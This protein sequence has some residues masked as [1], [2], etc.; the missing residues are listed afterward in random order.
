MRCGQRGVHP[1]GATSNAAN[2]NAGATVQPTNVQ[3]PRL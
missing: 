3:S 1:S 2:S